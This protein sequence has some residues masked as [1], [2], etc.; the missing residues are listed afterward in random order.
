MATAQ[1]FLSS[2]V[3]P[4]VVNPIPRSFHQALKQGF[5]VIADKSKLARR[6]R[7]GFVTLERNEVRVAVPYPATREGYRFGEPKAI[8]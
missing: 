6:F 5:R 7:I 1:K 3:P 4:Q 8:A 2:V